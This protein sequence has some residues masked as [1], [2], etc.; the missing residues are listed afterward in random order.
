LFSYLSG[1]YIFIRCFELAKRK[2]VSNGSGGGGY[3]SFSVET[4]SE[5][6]FKLRRSGRYGHSEDYIQDLAAKYNFNITDKQPIVVRKESG[7]P[8]PGHIYLLQKMSE[9]TDDNITQLSEI[10]GD[11]RL[12]IDTINAELTKCGFEVKDMKYEMDHICFRCET[13]NEYL[14]ICSQLSQQGHERSIES[15]V[16]GRMISIYNLKQPIDYAD[17]HISC[18]EIPS[19][20]QESFYKRGLEHA[21]LVVREHPL[22]FG[23]KMNEK[24]KVKLFD[25][26]CKSSKKENNPDISIRFKNTSSCG[27]IT[28]KFHELPIYE[29]V[30]I[31]KRGGVT[32]ASS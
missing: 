19:P 11:I 31:E 7:D 23:Q 3:L 21:E 26:E 22:L 13:Q 10:L 1:I 27:D 8:I 28:V 29:V 5:G 14:D 15:M 9:N 20:K 18:L 25:L 24:F 4:L 30:E 2:L 12:F 17:Y 32:T 16:G 6:T